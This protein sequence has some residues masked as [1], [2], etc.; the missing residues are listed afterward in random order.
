MGS[1]VDSVYAAESESN[2]GLL[3]SKGVMMFPC[4]LPWSKLGETPDKLP[5]ASRVC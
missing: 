5:T 3:T 2:H 4:S 1:I